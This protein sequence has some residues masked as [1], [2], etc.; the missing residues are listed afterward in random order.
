MRL[1]QV[2]I[3]LIGNSIKFTDR[4][5][6]RLRVGLVSELPG[7]VILHFAVI[8]TGMG[9]PREKQQVVFEA[10][11]Q[12]DGSASRRFGGT[13]LGCRFRRGSSS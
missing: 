13:G 7:E 1:R 9:I 5:E 8:D 10:F 3:N 6:I 2:L 4:G 12:A 11:A